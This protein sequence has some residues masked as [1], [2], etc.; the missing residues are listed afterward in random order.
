MVC[1]A[2]LYLVISSSKGESI[3]F[4]RRQLCQLINLPSEKVSALKE[5]NFNFR[6]Q[7]LS[8]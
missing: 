5:D 7:I 8:I 3:H 4:Q 1:V 2:M 6:E